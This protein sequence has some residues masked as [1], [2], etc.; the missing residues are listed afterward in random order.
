MSRLPKWFVTS[1]KVPK[2][3]ESPDASQVGAETLLGWPSATV[4]LPE[5]NDMDVV[6]HRIS[7]FNCENFHFFHNLEPFFR[8]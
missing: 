5:P 1:S 2:W 7:N 8:L 4:M 3:M 6:P